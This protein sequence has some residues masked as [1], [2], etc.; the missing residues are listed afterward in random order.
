MRSLQLF[1]FFIL[2]ILSGCSIIN[3]Q[4][5][6]PNLSDTQWKLMAIEQ[7]PVNLGD[8]ATLKFDEKENK[9]SGIAACNNFNAGYEMIRTAITFDNVITTKKYCEGKMDEENKIITNLQSVTRYDVKANMLY[10]YSKERL[11]LTYKR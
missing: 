5:D 7:N 2:A 4:A 8:N 6:L 1:T 11:V 9:I 10:F 3:E